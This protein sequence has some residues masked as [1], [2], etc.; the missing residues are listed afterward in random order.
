MPHRAIAN[1]SQRKRIFIVGFM[2]SGKTVVGEQMAKEQGMLFFDLDKE[3]EAY[4]GKSISEIFEKSGEAY[5][6]QIESIVLK[7]ISCQANCIIATGGGTPCYFD[8]MDFMLANGHVIYLKAS[9]EQFAQW[10]STEQEK[11]S[12]PLLKNIPHNN[13]LSVIAQMLSEREPHYNRSHETIIL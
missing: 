6:R 5:F 1:R 7:E 12:R 2:G 13:F 3:I 8:N 11:S 9:A 4:T 10:L